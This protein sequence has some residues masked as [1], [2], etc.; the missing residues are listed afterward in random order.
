MTSNNIDRENLKRIKNHIWVVRTP[1]GFR[2]LI[3]YYECDPKNVEAVNY[4]EQYPCTVFVAYTKSF[5]T[6]NIPD[7]FYCNILYNKDILHLLSELKFTVK[8]PTIQ[9]NSND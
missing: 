6:N 7:I 1:A 3:K 4:P 2:K 5:D 9:G 8:Q